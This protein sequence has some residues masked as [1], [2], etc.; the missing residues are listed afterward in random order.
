MSDSSSASSV[1][2]NAPQPGPATPVEPVKTAFPNPVPSSGSGLDLESMTPEDIEKQIVARERDMKYQIEAIK[3]ELVTIAD[4]VNIGGRPFLD[5]FRANPERALAIAG[6]VGATVGVLLGVWSRRRRRPEPDDGVEF[7]RARLAT[8]L[9]E[10]A[11]KVANGT[12]TD[13]AL[14]HT[15]K[16]VP[17]VYSDRQPVSTPGREH[18]SVGGLVLKTALGFGLKTALDLLTQ[19]LTD[20]DETFEALADAAD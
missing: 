5:V 6:A 16:T 4:D 20:E 14:K 3:N 13:D 19:R 7:V 17:A 10:A 1:P 2:A 15:F 11:W 9:D 18:D 8:L 12:T